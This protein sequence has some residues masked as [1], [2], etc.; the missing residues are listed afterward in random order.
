MLLLGAGFETTV[1]LLGNG[2]A[3]LASDE[4]LRDRLATDPELWPQAIDELLRYES[5]VQM[6]GRI[7]L[8]DTVLDGVEIRA[9]TMLALLLGAANRDPA[10]FPN[11][12]EFDLDRPN[13]RDHVAFSA[14]VHYCL[15]ANLAKMEGAT[16]LRML[17]ERFP[18]LQV[19]PNSGVRRDLQTLR[20]FESL[21]VRLAG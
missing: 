16:G 12:D 14:G 17:F 2:I 4:K 9:G 1:N 6:T 13:S 18:S 19:V 3:V 21:Q 15:G 20:G 11:P 5:P 8:R 10:V 7:A